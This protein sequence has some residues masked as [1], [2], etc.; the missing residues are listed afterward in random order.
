MKKYEDYQEDK[1]KDDLTDEEW[2]KLRWTKYKI[3]VPTQEDKKELEEAFEHLHY[4]DI[5]TDYIAVN[6]LVHEYIT[7]EN[8]GNPKVNNNIVV[9]ED[10]YNQ[11]NKGG[12]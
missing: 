1:T 6:Q 10:L 12:N 4:S 2:K 11:L 8:S 3:V 5:D 9:D 7:P